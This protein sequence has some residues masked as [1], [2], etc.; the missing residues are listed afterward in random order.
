MTDAKARWDDV[1]TRFAELG[2]HLK[3]QYNSNTM[4]DEQ[5]R[6]DVEDALRQVGDALDASFTT[7]G[8]AMRDPQM[9]DE[10]KRAGV[11]IADAVAATFYDVADEIRR[12]V[13]R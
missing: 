2:S 8:D 3:E 7:I 6:H 13:R 9:R 10:V 5:H 12:A 4:F 1:G 11:A